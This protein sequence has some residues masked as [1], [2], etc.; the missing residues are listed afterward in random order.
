MSPETGTKPYASRDIPVA[1]YMVY[2]GY[3]WKID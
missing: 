1:V 2:I 3:I